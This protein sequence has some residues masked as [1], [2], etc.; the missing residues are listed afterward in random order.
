[1]EKIDDIILVGERPHNHHLLHFETPLFYEI[2]K[3]HKR[4][5]FFL[6]DEM[7]VMG[8]VGLHRGLSK[9][10]K[11]SVYGL[12]WDEVRKVRDAFQSIA[13]K[14]AAKP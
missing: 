14:Y 5:G 13:E 3:K 6:A 9:H 10:V 1:M 7:I 12:T 2:S 8:I 11:L 4:R